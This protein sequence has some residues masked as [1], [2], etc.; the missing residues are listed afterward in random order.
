MAAAASASLE[1]A[2]EMWE[3]A[4][5]EH[6]EDVESRVAL[7]KTLDSLARLESRK[8]NVD[9]ALAGLRQSLGVLE[10]GRR[11]K[12]DNLDLGLALVRTHLAISEVLTGQR[13]RLP[14]ALASAETARQIAEGLLRAHPADVGCQTQ[15]S[16]AYHRQGAIYDFKGAPDQAVEVYGKWL[17]L[18]EKMIQ[19][20]PTVTRFKQARVDALGNLA[21]SQNDLGKTAEALANLQ[22]A[23]DFGLQLV[24]DH[25]TNIAFKRSLATTWN[26]MAGPLYALNRTPEALSATEA[27]VALREEISRVEPDDVQGLRHVAGA[28]YNVGLLSGA[29]GKTDAALSAYD[30]AQALQERLV[31]EH[32]DNPF[33]ALELASTLGNVAII[34]KERHKLPEARLGYERAIEILQKLVTA[35][36]ENAQFRNYLL[37]AR[38]NLASALEAMG[39]PADALKVLSATREA[40]EQMIREHPGVLLYQLDLAGASLSIGTALRRQGKFDEAL[41][42][43]QK[44]LDNLQNLLKQ[45]PNEPQVLRELLS[46]L[47]AQ[48]DLELDR[49]HPAAAV[50]SLQAAVK[51][52]ESVASP[53][54]TQIYNLA[55]CQARLVAAGSVEGSGMKA[56]EVRATADKAMA[57][58]NRAVSAG[59][60][61]AANMR[62]DA[63]VEAIR[64]RPDFQKL[65]KELEKK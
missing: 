53:S 27:V 62:T 51:M 43:V 33:I 3:A 65:L 2:K 21:S 20:H 38:S 50:K 57:T 55:C 42:V 4:I 64:K 59:Y 15:L 1:R 29:L 12:P 17:A 56:D 37:R 5:R 41:A 28:L 61:D 13:S 8:E 6:P 18:V 60:R 52:F 35:H 11:Q 58:L 49:K 22:R 9:G 16:Q 40:C 25:P 24:G 32:S 23:R 36:P 44:A 63:D 26:R 7:A 47:T 31:R 34:N 10:E 46:G 48:A 19:V 45:T 14:E 39:K 30:R 54:P